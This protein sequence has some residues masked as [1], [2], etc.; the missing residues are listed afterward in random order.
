MNNIKLNINKGFTLIEL[1]VATSLFSIIAVSGIS[2]LLGSQAAYKRISGNR[3]AVD[4]I[5]LVLDTMSR[6]IKFGSNYGCINT[7]GNFLA[8]SYYNYFASS[9]VFSDSI[10]NECN[11]FVYTPQGTTTQK[12]VYYLDTDKSTINEA[13]YVFNNGNYD[14]SLDFPISTSEFVVNSFWFDVKGTQV[15]DYLQPKVIILASG[16]ITF[17]KNSQRDN[18]ATTTFS[19]QAGASQRILDN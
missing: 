10:N 6:E 15:D 3:V 19:A 1:M 12:I 9:T 2:I 13:D 7:S 4:N 18:V 17:V 5:N 16:V 8:S 11:A 14:L